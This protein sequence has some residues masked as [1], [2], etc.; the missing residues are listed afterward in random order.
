MV[1]ALVFGQ[2]SLGKQC[3]PRS[4]C[5][6]NTIGLYCLIFNLHLE[7]LSN[8]LSVRVFYGKVI[9]CPN[10]LLFTHQLSLFFCNMQS[11][12]LRIP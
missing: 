9:G 10:I 1:L 3:R 12:N 11:T 6:Y 2:I 4:D 7:A 5:S 8:L